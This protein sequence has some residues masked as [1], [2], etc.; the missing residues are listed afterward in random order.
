[1]LYISLNC[2]HVNKQMQSDIKL[3]EAA[4]L[5]LKSQ[6]EACNNELHEVKNQLTSRHAELQQLELRVVEVPIQ[7]E[8]LSYKVLQQ[9]C[10][11]FFHYCILFLTK[12]YL[13]ISS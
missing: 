7:A 11:I 13:Y 10:Y 2:L 3:A 1:M 8:I 9:L 6:T 5:S 12:M 4:I